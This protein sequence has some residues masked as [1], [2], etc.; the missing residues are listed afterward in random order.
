[1]ISGNTLFLHTL[2]LG[3]LR[4]YEVIAHARVRA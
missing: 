1:M 2:R 4:D 3:C